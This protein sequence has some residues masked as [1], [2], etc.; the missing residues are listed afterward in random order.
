[1]FQRQMA[2][3]TARVDNYPALPDTCSLCWSNSFFKN[4]MQYNRS[5]IYKYLWNISPTHYASFCEKTNQS[6][7]L[8]DVFTPL[9][10]VFSNNNW[11]VDSFHLFKINEPWNF[12][13]VAF[14]RKYETFQSSNAAR[15]I[16]WSKTS[17]IIASTCNWLRD[18]NASPVLIWQA[19]IHGHF[20]WRSFADRVNPTIKAKHIHR[21][22]L[23]NSFCSSTHHAALTVLP[24][25]TKPNKNKHS[26]RCT[27]T[28]GIS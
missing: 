20:T 19:N 2:L 8:Q 15:A 10:Q 7:L 25:S 9:L 27:F 28:G 21:W 24:A 22:R 1:M 6:K 16:F 14:V 17:H 26:I 4:C 5:W 12:R 3:T 18:G 23:A 13:H 11:P